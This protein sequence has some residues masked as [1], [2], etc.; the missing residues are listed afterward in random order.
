M[1]ALRAFYMEDVYRMIQKGV[2]LKG[3][4]VRG[5]SVTSRLSGK[6]TKQWSGPASGAYGVCSH[7]GPALRPLLG[8]MLCCH[9]LNLL[10]ILEKG[11]LHFHFVVDPANYLTCPGRGGKRWIM[12]RSTSILLLFA[13]LCMWSLGCLRVNPRLI[14]VRCGRWGERSRKDVRILL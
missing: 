9:L 4:W 1:S 8:L 2:N 13:F 14:W 3:T 11:T 10:L 5:W 12:I 7:T 6:W